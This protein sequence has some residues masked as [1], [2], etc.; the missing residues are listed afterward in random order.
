VEGTFGPTG[1]AIERSKVQVFEEVLQMT[2][3]MGTV[4]LVSGNLHNLS[5]R[6]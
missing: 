1:K 6:R 3:R 2:A 5:G 4:E